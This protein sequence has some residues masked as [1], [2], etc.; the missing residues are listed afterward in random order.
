MKNREKIYACKILPISVKD[1]KSKYFINKYKEA[2]MH[3]KF[4]CKNIPELNGCF[5]IGEDYSCMIMEYNRYGDLDTFKRKVIKRP[6]LPET[7]ICYIAGGILNALSYIHRAKIIHM[8][9]KQ[10]NILVDDFLN[11]KVTDFSVSIDYKNKE[12]IELPLSGT[13]YFMSPEVIGRK[14]ILSKEASKIDIY[15]LGVLL[16]LLAFNDYP[17]ELDKVNSDNY[18]GIL[19]NIKEKDLTLPNGFSHSNMFKNFLKKC[20][21][22]NIKNRYN[23]YEALN[24]PWIKGYQ[25]LINEKEKLYSA[26]KFL[27]EIIVDDIIP[28]NDYIKAEKQENL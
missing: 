15:S 24:D 9:I 16:Y 10:Q 14:R 17:Y 21:D 6:Y 23:I 12:N 11:I 4:H 5:P 22:K 13:C 8:D 25:Y 18:A 1:K 26:G 27:T 2:L 7:F 20:L 28:F 3:R 19:N